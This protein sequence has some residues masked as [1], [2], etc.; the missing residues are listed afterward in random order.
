MSPTLGA[1]THDPLAINI[2][3]V[4]AQEYKCHSRVE[5]FVDSR[6]LLV[7]DREFVPIYNATFRMEDHAES[8]VSS[9]MISMESW[10]KPWAFGY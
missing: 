1:A 9:M 4:H 8:A 10:F 3:N 5:R 2:N 7:Q 6:E